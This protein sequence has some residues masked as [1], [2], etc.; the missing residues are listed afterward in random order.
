MILMKTRDEPAHEIVSPS[1][2]IFHRGKTCSSSPNLLIV[3]REKDENDTGQAIPTF[4]RFLLR[5]QALSACLLADIT[6]PD[7]LPKD[8]ISDW[9]QEVTIENQVMPEIESGNP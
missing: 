3:D 2:F 7:S 8:I 1:R 9:S 4:Y 6:P 5:D